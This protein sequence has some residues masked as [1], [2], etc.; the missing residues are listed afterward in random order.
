MST[1]VSAFTNK[2]LALPKGAIILGANATADNNI[3]SGT[4]VSVKVIEVDN[5]ANSAASY[6]KIDIATTASSSSVWDMVLTAPASQT[7]TFTFLAGIT[8]ANISMM[9]T[10][11]AAADSTANPSNAVNVRILGS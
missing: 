9:V 8:M 2:A 7:T 11:A 5:S 3:F 4:S 1:S 6:V 10:S